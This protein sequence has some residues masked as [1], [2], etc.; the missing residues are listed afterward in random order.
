MPIRLFMLF[1]CGLMLPAY[2]QVPQ[3]AMDAAQNG[4]RLYS[5][6]INDKNYAELGFGSRDEIKT[7]SFGAPYREYMI[8]LD[9]LK[10]YKKGASIPALLKG[11]ESYIFPITANGVLRSSL[12]VS[13]KGNSWAAASFGSPNKLRSIT[14]A[15]KKITGVLV[16]G[17]PPFCV[18]IPATYHYFLGYYNGSKLMLAP[19]QSDKI[20]GLNGGDTIKADQALPILALE[21]GEF[22]RPKTEDCIAFNP[23]NTSLVRT[24]ANRWTIVADSSNWLVNFAASQSEGQKALAIIKHYGMNRLCF[25]GRPNPPFQYLLVNGVAP[26]GSLTGEDCISFTPSELAVKK[27]NGRWLIVQGASYLINFEQNFEDAEKALQIIN[28]YGFTKIC[29]TGRPNG[30]FTYLRK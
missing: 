22:D 10:S 23:N 24:G 14:D 27:I 9:D 7:A 4:L 13:Q 5:Q 3:G 18:T 15:V 12:T 29:Y 17:Q 8:R 11:A 30:H 28:Y 26:S 2:G 25:V 20:L 19:V 16:R 21:A 1:I 6:L